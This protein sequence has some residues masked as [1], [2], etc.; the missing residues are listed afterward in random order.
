[1]EF[2]GGQLSSPKTPQVLTKLDNSGQLSFSILNSP[3]MLY[4]Q[5]IFTCFD[6]SLSV[7]IKLFDFVKPDDC[8]SF[9]TRGKTNLCIDDASWTAND[10]FVII[11]FNSST[12]AII[13]R[14]G[15]SLVAIYN[16]T[17]QNIS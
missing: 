17:L 3:H 10:A 12:F 2:I 7:V 9:D 11:V 6:T 5:A 8:P 4:C 15:N 13:P 14:L 1:V 16:P